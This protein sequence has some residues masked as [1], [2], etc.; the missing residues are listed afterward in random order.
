[1]IDVIKHEKA[2]YDEASK[3]ER[4]ANK[5]SNFDT[6]SLEDYAT[7]GKLSQPSDR[8]NQSRFTESEDYPDGNTERFDKTKQKPKSK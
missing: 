4:D 1:M 2:A 8:K 6:M 5:G 3:R 7:A